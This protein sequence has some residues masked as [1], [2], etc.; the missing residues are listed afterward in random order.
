M[1]KSENAV[2]LRKVRLYALATYTDHKDN[3]GDINLTALEEDIQAKFML[4]DEDMEDL[5]LSFYV[6]KLLEDKGLLPDI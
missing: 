6:W 3:L 2:F 1:N 4:S 5:D